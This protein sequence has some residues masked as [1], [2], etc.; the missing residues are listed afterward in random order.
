MKGDFVSYLFPGVVVILL[1][2]CGKHEGNV[3]DGST[4]VLDALAL[5]VTPPS[6]WLVKKQSG[7]LIDGLSCY[8]D[9]RSQ[10][11][12][13]ISR[14]DRAMSSRMKLGW[15]VENH[16][17]ESLK[18]LR[19]RKSI[20]IIS[21][22]PNV[23]LNNLVVHRVEATYKDNRGNIFETT[24]LFELNGRYV[25]VSTWCIQDSAENNLT[26]KLSEVLGSVKYL[27]SDSENKQGDSDALLNEYKA[28]R[29]NS[30]ELLAQY[31]AL[32]EEGKQFTD[33]GRSILQDAAEQGNA[34]AQFLLGMTIEFK[35]K[36][37]EQAFE[38]FLKSAN[39]GYAES[40]N[41]LG[42]HFGDTD[43][44]K[45]FEYFF[46]AAE[47]DHAG[48]AF[49]IATKYQSGNGVEKDEDKAMEWLKKSADLG[50]E[51]AI[52]LHKSLSASQERIRQLEVQE[53]RIEAELERRKAQ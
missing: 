8:P 28:L 23:K 26:Q 33:K 40:E 44:V 50:N 35:D 11:F 25:T 22:N 37:P 5:Q 4:I 42:Y 49:E 19:K 48:A 32:K 45:S 10:N 31:K 51:D 30:T 15:D 34:E 38:W 18:M 53:K 2:G 7:N 39:Q 20:N 12:S 41:A 29:D 21:S 6:G 1:A 16:V 52:K 24:D 46:K 13:I 3:S 14:T 17:N 36:D 9:T 43:P 47:K 27:N